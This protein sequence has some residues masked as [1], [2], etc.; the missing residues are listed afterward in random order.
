VHLG[1]IRRNLAYLA[2]RARV[3]IWAVI[4][5]DAY[6]HGAKQAARALEQAG[7]EGLAVALVE[8]GIELRE[9][10]ITRPILVMGAHYDSAWTELL[11]YGLTP[12]L[13]RVEQIPAMNVVVQRHREV[14][15]AVHVK[16]D[17]GMGRLGVSPCQLN[18]L[19]AA[20]QAAKGLALE[21]LMT[22]FSSAENAEDT[23]AQVQAFESATRYLGRCGSSASL[24]HA[25]NSAAL[26]SRS[27]VCYDA[28]RP[29]LALMGESPLLR[30]TL[31]ELEP[32]LQVTTAVLSIRDL[33]VGQS[34]GYERTWKATRP[35]RV[36]TIAMGYADGLNRR[37]SA[38]G[39]VL[40]RGKRAPIVGSVSMD[41]TT[42]DVTEVPG[43]QVNDEVVVLGEQV[44]L[45]G[46]DRIS[47][48]EM[49]QRQGTIAWEV[50]TS[51]SR[52]VPRLYIDDPPPSRAAHSGAGAA[53]VSEPVE[54]AY[55]ARSARQPARCAH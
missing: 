12:V 42:V 45:L 48:R 30:D 13:H 17:T 53:G 52:R 3:P 29:G 37:A 35:S 15:Y 20:L 26:L 21:G 19:A 41:L 27:D 7:V 14:P 8:E 47:A 49:A 31:P 39:E 54:S 5:A 34:S 2:R 6:G 22:H 18:Q 10:G 43:A 50:T 4:K 36:A 40:I 24:R 51:I 46:A 9:A 23:E 1:R 38:G 32:A 16:I 33:A 28:V 55:P 11:A 44:G 25:A